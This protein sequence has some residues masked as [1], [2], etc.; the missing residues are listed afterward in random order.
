MWTKK[1]S[2]PG[3]EVVVSPV[4][5]KTVAETVK[6]DDYDKKYR[7]FDDPLQLVNWQ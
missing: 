6:F 4:E 7:D 1:R 3:A 2:T 5:A